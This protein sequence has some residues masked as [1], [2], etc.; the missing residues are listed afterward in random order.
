[1]TSS[2]NCLP[3]LNCVI[4]GGLPPTMR[5]M[6]AA[7]ALAP[8]AMALS[9]QVPP[10]FVNWSAKTLTEA[11]SPA[12]VHQC[13]TSA[14][15]CAKAAVLETSAAARVYAKTRVFRPMTSSRSAF[16]TLF[17]IDYIFRGRLQS[18]RS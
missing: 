1:M 9:T 8:P 3:V 13:S 4:V 2:S 5:L 10:A 11:D 17:V 15:V 14:F 12:E 6:P 7:R 18:A 16:T